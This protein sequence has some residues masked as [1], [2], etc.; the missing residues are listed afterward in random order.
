MLAAI[1]LVAS[2]AVGAMAPSR[3]RS[4]FSWTILSLL[5]SPLLGVLLLI[6]AGRKTAGGKAGAR[7]SDRRAATTRPSFQLEPDT[8]GD[9]I[10]PQSLDQEDL[11]YVNLPGPG[12]YLAEIVGE[13]HYQD[14][15][16][17]ICGGKTTSGHNK[18]VDALLVW[19]DDNPADNQAVRVDIEG[20]TVGYISRQNARRIRQQLIKGG[21]AGV[22]G[23]CSAMIV[24]GWNRGG[25]DTGYY[26]VKLDLQ[27]LR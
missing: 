26:G 21:F 5:V 2:L 15:L 25:E 14:E 11:V 6:A 4:F 7:M 27:G 13:S 8:T 12:T 20:R 1:W 22:T 18:I 23:L 3:N 24:G 16:D 19:E 10:P 17:A 9:R